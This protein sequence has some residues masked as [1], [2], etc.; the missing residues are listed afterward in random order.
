MTVCIERR[1]RPES[2]LCDER[3]AKPPTLPND[4]HA[5]PLA[6]LVTAG[7]NVQATSAELPGQSLIWQVARVDARCHRY[8]VGE[9]GPAARLPQRSK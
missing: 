4:C 6:S 2:R 7:A 5:A 1:E 3:R 8:G 9:S